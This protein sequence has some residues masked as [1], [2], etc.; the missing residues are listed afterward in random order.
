LA[1]CTGLDYLR[2]WPEH[3]YEVGDAGTEG[4][5]QLVNLRELL[6]RYSSGEQ[7]LARLGS[8]RKLTSLDIELEDG[9]SAEGFSPL[10][11]L[12][13]LTE[14]KIGEGDVPG[15]AL[16]F[17]S[18]CRK[19]QKVTLTVSAGIAE[20]FT[21][22]GSLIEMRELHIK[23]DAVTDEAIRHLAPLKNLRTLLAHDTPVTPAGARWLADQLPVVTVILDKSVAKSPRPTITF[24]RQ[25]AERDEPASAMV[26]AHWFYNGWRSIA[27]PC[28]H[29]TEDGWQNVTPCTPGPAQVGF[30]VREENEVHNPGTIVGHRTQRSG[31]NY[32]PTVE[33]RDIVELAAPSVSCVYR[34]G[35]S[36]CL[37]VVIAS[38]GKCAVLE[39]EAP[40]SRFEEFRSLFLFVA[41]S[42]RVGEAANHGLG[43]EV[44]VAVAEL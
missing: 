23:G 20:D 22:F 10:S 33:E 21:A 17:L 4:L 2:V 39:C 38:E 35:N 31:N 18:P 29:H 40:K 30:Y 8:L 37:I 32:R 34:V 14:L 15:A 12:T 27:E 16:R 9:L 3:G 5:E 24:R 13:E 19:L 6:L 25:A 1:R 43:E 7:T 28:G 26:P 36:R 11:D 42:L 41:R 44:T